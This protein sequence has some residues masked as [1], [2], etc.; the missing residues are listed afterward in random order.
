VLQSQKV[1]YTRKFSFFKREFLEGEVVGE[2]ENMTAM[3]KLNFL[4]EV[5]LQDMSIAIGPSTD[6]FV[7]SLFC[8]GLGTWFG[9]CFYG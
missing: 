2:L 8:E 3:L 5:T 6:D 7:H 4:E 9:M 1:Q